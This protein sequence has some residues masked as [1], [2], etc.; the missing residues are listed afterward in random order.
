M[1]KMTREEI[2]E[3][4]K[5]PNTIVKIN[6]ELFRCQCGCNVFHHTDDWDCYHCNACDRVYEGS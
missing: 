6:G 4:K 2:L 3:Y 5:N 1:K